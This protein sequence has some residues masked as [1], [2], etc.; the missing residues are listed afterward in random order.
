LKAPVPGAERK[1]GDPGALLH[2]FPEVDKEMRTQP[3]L[4]KSQTK[5]FK[6]R[7]GAS[8]SL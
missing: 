1:R 5:N 8:G 2:G 4:N 7:P 3:V 6:L